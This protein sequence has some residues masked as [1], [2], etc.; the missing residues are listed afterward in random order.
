MY[1]ALVSS[2]LDY[3]DNI[4][5]IPSKIYQ[6]HLGRALNIL[7]EKAKR[8]QYQAAPAITGVWQRSSHSKIYDELVWE[9]V[10]DRRKYRLVPQIQE[11]LNNN[12]LSYV[13]DK[14]PPNCRETF[15][16]NIRTSC[17]TIICKSNR[18]LD[19]FFPHVIAAWNLFM[20]IFNYKEVT[21]IGI[22]KIYYFSYSS[23]V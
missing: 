11:R 12:T 4:Y 10:S 18:Y 5:H 2:H 9:T 23:R 21:S 19:S 20:E 15:S 3:C 22:L 17:H 14:L 7:M 6:L 13:K 1:K 8:V 16:G